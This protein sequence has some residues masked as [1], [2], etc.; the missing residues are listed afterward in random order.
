MLSDPDSHGCPSSDVHTASNIPTEEEGEKLDVNEECLYLP[1]LEVHQVRWQGIP[2]ANSS[3]FELTFATIQAWN[4]TEHAGG[5]SSPSCRHMA[6]ESA[7]R[8][9]LSPAQGAE[10]SGG[11]QSINQE[12]T[13][14]L[15]GWTDTGTD[16]E[17]SRGADGKLSGASAGKVSG[18]KAAGAGAPLTSAHIIFGDLAVSCPGVRRELG[19]HAKC[20]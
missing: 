17:V 1:S 5:H 2:A 3:E 20:A 13:N 15:D 4:V 11:I 6:L 16:A 19:V 18:P 14:V 12:Q 10:T 7:V 9:T 8:A